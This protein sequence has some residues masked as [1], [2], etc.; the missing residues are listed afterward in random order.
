MKIYRYEKEDGGGPYFTRDGI[1]RSNPNIIMNDNT[2]FGCQ[3]LE[4]LLNYFEKEP[5]EIL[6]GCKIA[7]YIIPDNEVQIEKRQVVFS[8]N[9]TPSYFL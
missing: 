3:S 1:L 4:L 9:Y 6:T 8:K 5:K 7:V 2:L